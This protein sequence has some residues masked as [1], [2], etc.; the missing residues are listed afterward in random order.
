MT[1]NKKVAVGLSGGVD[2][3][4]AALLLKDAGYEVVGVYMKCWDEKGDGCTAKEDRASAVSVAS[5]LGIKFE[6]LDY[7][8]EY[9]ERVIKYFYDEYS[10]GR[11][12]NPD[13]MCNKEIKF[14]MFLEWA[15]AAGFD[16]VATG[17]YARVEHTAEGLS[18]LLMGVDASKDQSYF[19]YR[20]SQQQLQKVLFPLGGLLKKDVRKMAKAAG[21]STY[22]RPDSQ[23]ICFIG[24]VNIK[25]FLQRE[26]K[27]KKG[28]VYHVDG[29]EI[30]THDGVWFYTIGQR[31]GF[32]VTKY[33]G[34]PLYV[35]DK[36]VNTNK[37]VVGFAQDV[38]KSEFSV[39][40]L[41][42]ISG[43][44]PAELLG[45]GI[46]V[47]IR[48]LGKLHNCKVSGKAADVG[49]FVSMETASFGVAPGQSAVFYKG[50]EVLGGGVIQ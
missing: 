36:D 32:E 33:Y 50:S 17:H 23:G 1:K 16:Y 40:E 18:K 25:D 13:I 27:V 4:V 49:L 28:K 29:S 34:L 44:L 14:G 5:Q 39:S 24:K 37:L 15:I 10:A 26:L 35:V 12:P 46:L 38:L 48:H 7:T 20:L 8:Q 2:S 22:S 31:H 43:E 42:W 11:T 6:S 19:L 3:S 9:S 47:R 45:D 30:G 41:T 21:L